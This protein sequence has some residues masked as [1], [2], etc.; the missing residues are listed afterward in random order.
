[1]SIHH[2]PTQ[3]ELEEM[4][5]SAGLPAGPPDP[6][7]MIK[8]LQARLEASTNVLGVDGSPVHWV[9]FRAEE[10]L[11]IRDSAMM[12]PPF[13][14][15]LDGI[16]GMTEDVFSGLLNTVLDWLVTVAP[17]TEAWPI[18]L[19]DMESLD[20]VKREILPYTP[21]GNGDET[22]EAS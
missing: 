2:F 19:A 14:F 13:Q 15:R 1:M 10:G 12:G 20:G 9:V 4:A 22:P 11:V 21:I 3:Q 7:D 8:V 16:K 6:Q 5:A 17:A 18:Q